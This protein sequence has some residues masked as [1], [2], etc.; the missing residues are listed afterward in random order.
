MRVSRKAQP[1]PAEQPAT[2]PADEVT[3]EPAAQAPIPTPAPSRLCLCRCGLAITSKALFKPGHDA[4]AVGRLRDEVALGK[5]TLTEALA[6]IAP[7]SDLLKDKVTRAVYRAKSAQ[8]AREAAAQPVEP[9]EP[10]QPV[11]GTFK[12]VQTEAV[13]A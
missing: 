10:A 12:D 5:M 6:T 8:Q 13:E 2:A 4:K 7:A 1:K 11:D 9:T 3:P